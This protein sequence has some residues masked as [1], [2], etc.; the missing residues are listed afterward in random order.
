[1]TPAEARACFPG[2]SDKVFLDAACVSLMPATAQSALARL[3][4]ALVSCP[5]QDASAHHIALDKL[6]E[7]T[8][9]EA[10]R[11]LNCAADDI[12]LVESTTQGLQA[13]AACVPLAE[14]ENILIGELEFLGLAVPWIGRRRHLAR[15]FRVI[16]HRNGRLEAADFASAID[17]RTR[18]ILLSSVQWNN[19]FRAEL[20]AFSQLAR[21]RGLVLVV[22]AIQQLGVIGLD[23]QRTPVDFLVCGGHKWLNAPAGR[24]LLYISPR[25]RERYPPPW[26]GYLNV[27]EPQGGWAH[28]FATPTIPAVRPY[29]YAPSAKAYELGGT[30]N[31]PGNVVLGEAL[32]II[33][34][35]GTAAIERHILELAGQL[36]EGLR[37]AGASVVSPQDET[38]RSGI[39]TF[40]LGRGA[41]ADTALLRHLLDRRVFV[42]QRYTGGVGGIRVSTHFF[43]N[44]QDLGL[45][46]EGVRTFRG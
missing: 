46:L 12:A 15:R 10:A 31:Y 18:M 29:E 1:M 41:E 9:R 42:S 34:A 5:E 4:E 32:A 21:D 14:D 16:A 35:I 7:K 43:N 45:L 44:E 39:T 3:G 17:S 6:A 2:L 20:A 28:Y 13:V 36:V 23:V 19:G 25:M 37:S 33:N 27:A 22:D 8:V 38:R 26:F 30:A 40:T 11:L 24:G